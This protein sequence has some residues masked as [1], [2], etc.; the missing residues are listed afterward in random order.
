MKIISNLKQALV[1]AAFTLSAFVI[2]SVALKVHNSSAQ[3]TT[4]MPSS[5]SCALLLTLPVPYGASAN[6]VNETGYN[7]IGQVNFTSATAGTFAGRIVNPT[8]QQNNS[9]YISSGSTIDFSN[10]TVATAPMTTGQGFSGGYLMTLSGT[11]GNQ[12]AAIELTAVPTNNGKT[13]MLISS[14]VGTP[15]SPGIGP[16]SGICQL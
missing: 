5:G 6:L 10:W 12:Q 14:G 16:A 11:V 1:P 2:F 3:S 9:P 4:G 8:F 15:N 7:L 13:I